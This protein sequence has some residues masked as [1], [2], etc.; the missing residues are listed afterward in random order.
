MS[1]HAK[2]LRI[3]WASTFAL[4]AI[5][6]FGTNPAAAGPTTPAADESGTTIGFKQRDA[7]AVK[8]ATTKSQGASATPAKSIKKGG[9]HKTT[10]N[11]SA[12]R[13]KKA[14]SEVARKTQKYKISYS[15]T[16]IPDAGGKGGCITFDEAPC[17][18]NEPLKIRTIRTMSGK[19]VA[20]DT[21]CNAEPPPDLPR[22]STE[23]PTDVVRAIQALRVIEVSPADFQSFP[24]LASE[25]LSQPEGFSLR[26]GN[27]HMYAVPNPQVFDVD[28]YDEPVKIRATPESYLWSYGDGQRKRTQ[29]PGKPMPDHTFDQKTETS[30]VYEATGDY[31]IR[32]N[33]VYRGE[34]SVDGGP[35]RPVM[36]TANVPSEPMPMSVWRT[37]K[38]LVD[39]NCAEDPDGPACDSPFLKDSPN[40]K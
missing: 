16:C 10:K 2:S 30:H 12:T 15:S 39:Q 38:L 26:H 33:T 13:H 25:V 8:G 17:P 28:I 24:I 9:S 35:W 20:H 3:S 18:N 21:Y 6:L 11:R 36:G 7:R 32:L 1:S 37:K 19:L 23:N 34:Y 27:A 31:Q 5:L 29:H 4:G 40:S 22:N 14:E